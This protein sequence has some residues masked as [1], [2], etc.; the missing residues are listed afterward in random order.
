LLA[1]IVYFGLMLIDILMQ[2]WAYVN[3]V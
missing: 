1:K 3:I 2:F